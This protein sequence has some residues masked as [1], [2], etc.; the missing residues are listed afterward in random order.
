MKSC[1]GTEPCCKNKWVMLP[2]SAYS[3]EVV[4]PVCH[5]NK[6]INNWERLGWRNRIPA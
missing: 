4:E 2:S 5:D 1:F 6:I 3:L